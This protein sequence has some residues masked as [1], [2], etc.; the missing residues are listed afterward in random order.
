MSKQMLS[1]PLLIGL[2]I[3]GIT[4]LLPLFAPYDPMLTMPNQQ[5]QFISVQHLLGTDHLGRDVFSRLL[6]G[7]EL[8]ISATFIST[9]IALILGTGLALCTHI[10]NKWGQ[11]ITNSL[12]NGL[13][14]FPSIL[15][16]FMLVTLAG[17]GQGSLILG[18]GIM[19]APACGRYL[20]HAVRSIQQTAYYEASLSLGANRTELIR[21]AIIPNM[22]DALVTYTFILFPMTLLNYGAMTFLGL[23]APYGT[24]EWGI[25][26]YDGRLSFSVTPIPMLAPGIAI[27]LTLMIF[28]RLGRRW[29]RHIN[30]RL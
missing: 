23:G 8:S 5:N 4:F 19:F 30:H 7:A 28:Q 21:G 11:W 12:L 2:V 9:G 17:A 18:T 14:A 29:T 26:L 20:S 16:V 10:P 1:N 27:T 6:Y 13:L 3:V 25:I 24:P 15:W 22:A